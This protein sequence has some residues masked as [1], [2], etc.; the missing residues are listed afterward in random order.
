MEMSDKRS[1]GE[2]TP[3]AHWVRE[4]NFIMQFENKVLQ[5]KNQNF[6]Q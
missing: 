3:G 2:R 1:P 6:H 4:H 5:N